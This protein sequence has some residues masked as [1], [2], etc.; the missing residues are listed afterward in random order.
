M[1]NRKMLILF[2]IGDR[3]TYGLEIKK[4]LEDCDPQSKISQGVMYTLLK[5]LEEEGLIYGYKDPMEARRRY[6]Q[7]T[8]QGKEC[9]DNILTMQKLLLEG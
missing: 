3:T 5:T 4:R 2:A 9:I 8:K 7:I 6:Y 1:L